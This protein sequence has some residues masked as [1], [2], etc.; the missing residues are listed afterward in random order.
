MTAGDIASVLAEV[1]QPVRQYSLKR[2]PEQPE[3]HVPIVPRS[4]YYRM[5][6]KRKP[7]QN[8]PPSAEELVLVAR[9]GVVEFSTIFLFL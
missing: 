5:S 3:V 9:E 4:S 6:L 7:L 2:N 8:S 1:R